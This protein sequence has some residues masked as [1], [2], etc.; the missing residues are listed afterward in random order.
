MKVLKKNNY[1][2]EIDGL[3]AIAVLSVIFFHLSFSS[4]KG[5]F[6]GVDI[7]FVISGYLITKLIYDECLLTGTFDFKRF[8]IRRARRLLP[9]LIFTF[10]VTLI[11]AILLLSPPHLELYAKSLIAAIGSVSNILFWS[12]AGYF[13]SESLVKPLLHTWSLGVE[14]QY[15]L[16]WPFVLFVALRY[17]S[18]KGFL[19]VL[20]L[21]AALSLIGNNIFASGTRYFD[22]MG[23]AF[24]NGEENIF[25]LLPFRVFEFSIGG[26]LVS[27]RKVEFRQSIKELLSLL[28]GGLIAY[29][30]F[31]FSKDIIFP[32]YNALIPCAGA[33]LIILSGETKLVGRLLSNKL[34]VMTGLISYSLYLIHWPIIVYWE[35]WTFEELTLVEKAIILALSLLMA[36]LMFKF[37]ETPFR[38][39]RGVENSGIVTDKAFILSVVFLLLL[40]V[41]LA[42]NILSKDGWRWRIPA[43]QLSPEFWEQIKHSA[44]FHKNNY[45]GKGYPSTGVMSGGK[46]YDLILIG[47]S[48]GKHYAAGIDTFYARKRRLSVFVA[49]STSCLHLPKFTRVGTNVDWNKVCAGQLNAGLKALDESPNA[50][51]IMSHSWVAQLSKA[52]IIRKN[53]SLNEK[54]TPN[55]LIT[56]IHALKNMVEGHSIIIIGDV[57]RSGV[58]VGVLHNLLRPSFLLSGDSPDVKSKLYR[59]RKDAYFLEKFNR[60]LK[61]NAIRT[62][63]YLFLDPFDA[64]CDDSYCRNVDDKGRLIYS[65]KAHLS[66]VGSKYVIHYFQD[67][68]D[69]LLSASK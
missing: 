22:W 58:D 11:F 41:G 20:I 27:L 31:F 24:L 15:Y 66:L 21:S 52:A 62:G 44:D 19:T 36:F 13:D 67:K 6:V 37:I 64:L 54:V 60:L 4:F 40:F 48:H 63:D 32:S 38:K 2:P 5:G 17:F 1:Y 28:G 43:Y 39:K 49:A 14:E 16:I 56:G 25:Y 23:D 51:I 45:G 55:D 33:A 10:L 47:D 50:V 30:I 65:D 8:Y 7:F 46:P 3:R 26:A 9:S 29:S 68:I 57:P 69:A 35:Y 61:E 34:L 18:K 53:G 42:S 12:E 59:N